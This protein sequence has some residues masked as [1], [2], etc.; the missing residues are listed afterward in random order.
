MRIR[1]LPPVAVLVVTTALAGCSGG[2]EQSSQPPAQ[3]PASS[4]GPAQQSTAGQA[5][6]EAAKPKETPLPGALATRATRAALK[7]Y[8]GEVV[9]AEYDAERPGLY[10]VEIRK[11]DGST[12]EVYLSKSF[13]VV[14]T[15][16]EGGAGA[17]DPDGD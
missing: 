14:G 6:T 3:A 9:K 4:A 11:G 10:A 12:V 17:S 7:A 15:K 13:K 2:Q 1:A 16:D 8:P 5:P